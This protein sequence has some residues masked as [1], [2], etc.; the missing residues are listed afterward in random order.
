MFPYQHTQLISELWGSYVLSNIMQKY[1]LLMNCY[2]S[3]EILLFYHIRLRK[4]ENTN[5]KS[6]VENLKCFS[7]WFGND[8]KAF[9]LVS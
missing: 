5:K 2:H 9:V 4:A 7:S 3:T 1:L 8:Y 6:I